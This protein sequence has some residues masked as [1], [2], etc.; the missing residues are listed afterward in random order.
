M[1]SSTSKT[2]IADRALQLLGMSQISSSP[3]VGNRGAKSIER[4]YTPT[5]IAE[6]TKHF[7]HFATKRAQLPAS[8]TKPLHTKAN[9]FTLPGDYLM[10][11]PED[12]FG[13]FPIKN[14]WIIEGNTIVTDDSA[15]L[16]IRYISSDVLE[17]A[18]DAIFCE[19]FSAAL[20]M[21]CCEE[22]TNS[23]TKF[24]RVSG[25]YDFQIEKAKQ[26]GSILIQKPRAPASPWLTARL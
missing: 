4:A 6:L 11:A 1:P 12:E 9:A 2:T 5:K 13:D 24:N 14:D 7:W 26:R 21:A 3:Q 15:P 20:A 16:L 10:L 18:F 23:E 8:G 25:I 22:L 17:S 19:A